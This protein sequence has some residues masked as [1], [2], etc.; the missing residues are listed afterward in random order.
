MADNSGQQV[1]IEAREVSRYFRGGTAREVRAVDGVSLQIPAGGCAALAGPSGSGKTSLLSLL[2]L[3]D[4]PTQGDVFLEGRNYTG[5]S[6]Y[7]LARGR[8]R[9]AFVFQDF[10]LL[11]RLTA[12]D[13]IAY[14]LIPRRPDRAQRRDLARKW[15]QRV[16]LAAQQASR[17]TELSGGECQRVA[18]ARAL[19]CDPDIL[20]VDEPTSN[21]DRD[22]AANVISMLQETHNAGKTVVLATHDE[23]LLKLAT[24]VYHMQAGRIVDAPS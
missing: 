2:G 22:S 15:L 6:D 9:M 23:R 14:A 11:P 5:C 16:G 17:P 10:G 4:R 7:E 1:L 20:L 12:V 3:L 8:R 21:L 24:H 19:A 18:V 13:N